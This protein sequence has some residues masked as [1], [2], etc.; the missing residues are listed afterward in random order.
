MRQIAM[1][2][3]CTCKLDLT[4]AIA[5]QYMVDH[6]GH[7]RACKKERNAAAYRANPAYWVEWHLGYRGCPLDLYDQLL[8][9]QGYVCAGCECDWTDEVRPNVDHDHDCCEGMDCCPKCIRG[10]LCM[11]CNVWL[12]RVQEDPARLPA[13]LV[14]YLAR[15]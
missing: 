13:H 4:L 14:A 8:I 1:N 9:D 2:R 5:T 3:C 11:Q 12:G 15:F 10:L 6:G 7:C